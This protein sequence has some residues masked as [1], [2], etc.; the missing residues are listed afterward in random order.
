M[1]ERWRE[2][3]EEHRDTLRKLADSDLPLSEDARKLL[4]EADAE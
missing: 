4:K 3:V 2:S 1:T